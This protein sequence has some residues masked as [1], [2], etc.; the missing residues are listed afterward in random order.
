MAKR[1]DD[2]YSTGRRA[3]DEHQPPVG[4][5]S[6]VAR[7]SRNGDPRAHLA[8]VEHDGHDEVVVLDRDV[9]LLGTARRAR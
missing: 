3:R 7:A 1:I 5:D 9:R 2:R 4:A 8:G 6:D